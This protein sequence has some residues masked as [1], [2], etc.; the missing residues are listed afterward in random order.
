MTPE[1]AIVG[2]RI[3]TLDPGRPFAHA[4]ACAEG[5]VIAVGDD[6]EIRALGAA[7]VIDADGRSLVPGLVDGHAHPIWGHE[8]ARGVCLDGCMSVASVSAA[9][10]A[11]RERVRDGGWVFGW[12]LDYDAFPDG[13]LDPSVLERA[14]G[15]APALVRCVD[16]HA[17]IATQRALALAG[18]TEPVTFRDGAEIEFRDGRPTGLLHEISAILLVQGAA[19]ALTAAELRRLA[20]GTFRDMAAAGLTAVHAMDGNPSHYELLRA[21]EA[22][23]DLPLRVVAP[24]WIQPD[25]DDATLADWLA[26]VGERGR[27]WRGGVAK[28]FADGVIGSG[29]AWLEEPD[30]L[31]DGTAPFW[32]DPDRYAEVVARFADAG[33]QCVT[34]AIGDRAMR[35][36]LDAYAAAGAAPGVRHRIEHLEILTNALVTRLAAEGVVA[37][38]QPIHLRNLRGDGTGAWMERLG[39]ERAARAFRTADVLRAGVVLALGSDWPIAPFDPRL[40]LAAAQLRRN[41]QLPDEPAIVPSQALTASQAL[42]GYTL[43]CAAAVGEPPRRIAPGSPA[44]FTGFAADP[45]D[46]PP[47][48][49]LDVPV[50]V[51]VVDGTVVHAE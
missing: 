22:D 24:L 43:G 23:G 37:S 47:D 50:W 30:T 35:A 31:G 4:V 40:G 21:L 15:G 36:A 38:M 42:E 10:A 44:H 51:T 8:L 41:P 45:V 49:L 1:L 26:L 19:P 28:F 7:E 27:R 18:V 39:S 16:G 17:A 2:A 13:Q 5:R 20:L 25:I 29:T 48:E 14:V 3:R 11:E 32:P 46:T 34:H 12:S 9:L 33:F 6:A